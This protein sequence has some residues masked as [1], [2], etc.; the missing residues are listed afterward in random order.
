MKVTPTDS[1]QPASMAND[2]SDKKVDSKKKKVGSKK[3]KLSSK[4][5]KESIPLTESQRRMLEERGIALANLPD[6]DFVD[7]S[8]I[9]GIGL[10]DL[11]DLASTPEDQERLRRLREEQEAF[12]KAYYKS[13]EERKEKEKKA[14]HSWSPFWIV[15]FVSMLILSVPLLAG[16]VNFWGS[17]IVSTFIGLAY[18]LISYI[19]GGGPTDRGDGFG[20][21]FDGGV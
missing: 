2:S 4:N 12:N 8:K 6:I 1:S 16:K 14:G 18:Q 19:R 5:K 3:K 13:Y 7:L 10:S 20:D 9:T 11:I 21:N 17:V 15:F